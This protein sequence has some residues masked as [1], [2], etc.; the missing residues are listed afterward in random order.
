MNLDPQTARRKYRAGMRRLKQR[1]HDVLEAMIAGK[2][3]R[4]IAR[5]LSIGLRT[6][7]LDR[8]RIRNAFGVRSSCA[9]GFLVGQARM[10]DQEAREVAPA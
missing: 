9:I 5:E 6:V 2:T 3:C 4:Q 7:E 10:A 1:Q 8:S